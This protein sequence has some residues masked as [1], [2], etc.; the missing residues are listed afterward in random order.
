MEHVELY[1]KGKYGFL[2]NNENCRYQSKSC[3]YWTRLNWSKSQDWCLTPS[4]WEHISIK[5]SA[6]SFDQVRTLDTVQQ[7]STSSNTRRAA[8]TLLYF[9]TN[10]SKTWR[11]RDTMIS[12]YFRL[13]QYSP[14]FTLISSLTEWRKSM[15][16][17]H[18][19]KLNKLLRSLWSPA[20]PI[21][22]FSDNSYDVQMMVIVFF[23]WLISVSPW[24][25]SQSFF[26][27]MTY[28]L[29]GR[30]KLTST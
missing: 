8:H 1:W 3:L 26:S 4:V 2:R 7:R 14:S 25:C 21:S 29:L 24:I 11:C 17:P 23:I 13:D 9:T 20:I 16:E 12:I 27:V 15:C 5:T 22:P 18:L 28:K 10:G 6:L 30:E 19:N